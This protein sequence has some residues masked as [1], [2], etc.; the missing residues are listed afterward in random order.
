[1]HSYAPN[2][3]RYCGA[4]D[5]SQKIESYVKTRD[6]QLESA[7]RAD[8]ATL[9]AAYHYLKLIADANRLDVFDERVAEA[10]WIGND[11]L[12]Q[13]KTEDVKN[14]FLGRFAQSDYWGTELAN[15]FAARIPSAAVAHHSFHVFYT[16]FMSAGLA[17]TL[18]NLDNC[19][20]A[21]A[22]V[23]E[24]QKNN[25]LVEYDSLEIENQKMALGKTIQKMISK[26]FD[27][28]L[29]AG[30]W[31]SMH[32]NTYCMKISEQQRKNLEYYTALNMRAV[33]A[34]PLS[35]SDA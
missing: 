12:E 9:T 8:Y 22:K 35:S 23:I 28:A 5:Y 10:Y 30:D 7:L 17:N 18:T 24:I 4:A 25:L 19:R 1:R 26:P 32:W 31:I 21:G 13:V 11:L 33:N 27:D 2:K 16:H 3:L 15:E 20:I 34:L 6:A 14:L 29:A